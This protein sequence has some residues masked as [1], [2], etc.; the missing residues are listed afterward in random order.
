MTDAEFFADLRYRLDHLK[1]Q[2]LMGVDIHSRLFDASYDD[3]DIDP[4]LENNLSK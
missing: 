1:K 4:E 2:E 3:S